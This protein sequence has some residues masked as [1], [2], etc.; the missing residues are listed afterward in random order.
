MILT[1][2]TT[3]RSLDVQPAVARGGVSVIRIGN[4]AAFSRLGPA[5]QAGAVIPNTVETTQQSTAGRRAA[6]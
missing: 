1:S 6:Q 4:A 2:V 3:G 5:E